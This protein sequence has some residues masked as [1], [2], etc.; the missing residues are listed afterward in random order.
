MVRDLYNVRL[1]P[2]EE[3]VS[4]LTDDEERRYRALLFRELGNEIADKG[5][6]RYPAY[7][8]EDRRRLVDVAH[9]LSAHWGLRVRVE[10]EDLTRVR[11]F[12]PGH[13]TSPTALPTDVSSP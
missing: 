1:L 4:P 10:A 9:H 3:T 13:G 7:T 8:V 2:G 6:A 11:L 5:Y 12:V